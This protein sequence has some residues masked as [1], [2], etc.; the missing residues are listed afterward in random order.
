MTGYT[1]PAGYWTDADDYD[2]DDW[3]YA[4]M[5]GTTTAPY[6]VWVARQ[7]DNNNDGFANYLLELGIPADGGSAPS[8][9]L[10]AHRAFF[11]S[12]SDYDRRLFSTGRQADYFAARE[13]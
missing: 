3:C 13:D 12:L 4:Q 9:E 6:W 2:S 8:D 7:R 10:A 11:D 5:T 1:V